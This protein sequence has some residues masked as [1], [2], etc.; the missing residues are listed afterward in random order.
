[1]SVMNPELYHDLSPG[2]ARQLTDKIRAGLDGVY[3]LIIQ[4]FQHRIWIPLGYHSWDEYVRREFGNLALRP[5]LE[6]RDEVLQSMRDAGM[7][8]RSIGTATQMHY[9]TVSKEL[10]KAGVENSTP[11][12]PPSTDVIGQD[13]KQYSP[14]KPQSSPPAA[15]TS[16]SSGAMRDQQAHSSSTRT[17]SSDVDLDSVLDSPAAEVGVIPLDMDEMRSGR[18]ARIR[19]LIKA[20]N[21]RNVGSLPRTLQLAEQISALV[22]PLSGEI[23]VE[24]YEYESLSKDVSAAVRQFAYVA[25]T[26]SSADATF[27]SEQ[28]YE[29]VVEDLRAAL[30]LLQDSLQVVVSK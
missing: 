30:D 5:P 25:K 7:S 4:A 9:S 28:A 11:E 10:D 29:I 12:N 13:G 1:M 3:Q 22:S 14:T 17:R 18:D 21:N 2:N 19:K 8:L 16:T 27:D 24:T 26:L 6:A 23:N 15:V 20:F